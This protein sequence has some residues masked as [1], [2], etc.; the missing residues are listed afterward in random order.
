MAKK[1]KKN[2]LT[3][4]QRDLLKA[5]GKRGIKGKRVTVRFANDDVPKFLKNLDKFEKASR[6]APPILVK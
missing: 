2:R 6:K 1:K 5:M 4:I 3:K